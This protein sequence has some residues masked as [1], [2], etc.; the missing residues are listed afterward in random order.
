M[1]GDASEVSRNCVSHYEARQQFLRDSEDEFHRRQNDWQRI[2]QLERALDAS[3][4]R[5]DELC[6]EN[7]KLRGLVRDMH[8]TIEAQNTWWDASA[9]DSK[10][11]ADRM[12]ELGVEVER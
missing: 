8:E 3:T 10:R 12:R 11:Y 9:K 1:S 4:A 7:E 5:V 2:N 6:K